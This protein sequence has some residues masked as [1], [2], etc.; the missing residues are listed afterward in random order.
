MINYREK[1]NYTAVLWKKTEIGRIMP[2]GKGHFFSPRACG[3]AV[4]SEVY[5]SVQRVKQYIE[6]EQLAIHF[7]Y[8]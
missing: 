2:Q 8:G 5:P 7:Y 4:K 1:E 3:G 6:K